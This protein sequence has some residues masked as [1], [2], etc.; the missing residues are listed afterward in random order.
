VAVPLVPLVS[1]TTAAGSARAADLTRVSLRLTLLTVLPAALFLHVGAPALVVLF[2]G[3]P[4]AP[5]GPLAALLVLA[6]FFQALGVIVWST[7]VGTGRVWAGLW[8]QSAG[9]AA[10]AALTVVLVPAFGLAGAGWAHVGAAALPLALGL[11]YVARRLHVALGRVAA[12][13]PLCAAGWLAAWGLTLV[14]GAGLAAAL[15]LALAVLALEWM[16]LTR[17]ETAW[18]YAAVRRSGAS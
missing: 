14:G 9:Y 5:A 11:W 6:A 16:A 12:L 3:A 7:L 8:I 1:E 15:V 2:Y 18:L 4:Y 13:V 10:L 17:E